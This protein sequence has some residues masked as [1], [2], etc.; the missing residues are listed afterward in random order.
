MVYGQEANPTQH[1]QP[2]NQ[3]SIQAIFRVTVVSRTTPAINYHHRTG[4]TD[5]G[6]HGTDLMPETTGYAKVQSN[7]GATKITVD[8][9]KMRPVSS[10]GPE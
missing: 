5:V 3:D 2:A 7:T 6:M 1:L 4:S 10:F 9:K 8:L